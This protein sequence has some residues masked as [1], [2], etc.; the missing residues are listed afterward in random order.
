MF[1]SCRRQHRVRWVCEC[2]GCAYRADG[3][4]RLRGGGQE[5]LIGVARSTVREVPQP[6]PASRACAL[7]GRGRGP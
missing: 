5:A 7:G 2:V 6:I 4:M 3:Q 1:H